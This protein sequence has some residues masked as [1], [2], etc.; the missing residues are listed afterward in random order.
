MKTLDDLRKEINQVDQELTTSFEKRMELVK[1]IIDYKIKH[2]LAVFDESREKQVLENTLAYLKD[3]NLK[4]YQQAFMKETMNLSKSFQTKILNQ[5]N[6]AF[7]GQFGAFSHLAAKDLFPYH[8]LKNYLTFNDIFQALKKD[9]THF[10]VL[11]LENSYY[12]EIGDILDLLMADD[13][14]INASY[15]LKVSHHLMGL[16]G[17]KL[18][19][20]KEVYSHP[21]AISQCS[22]F[23]KG[24][25]V[26]VISYPN[27]ALAAA[28]ILENKDP[29]LA[30]IAS[31]AS[32]E[33]FNLEILAEN[34]HDYA[35]NFTRFVVVSKHHNQSGKYA[36]LLFTTKHQSGALNQILSIISNY[37]FNLESIKSRPYH[38]AAWSYYFYLELDIENQIDKYQDLV[39]ELKLSGGVVKNLGIYNRKDDT[40]PLNLTYY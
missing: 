8:Q 38:Q 21:Q 18:S 14:F 15:D 23:L 6:I 19:E 28:L 25:N 39:R 1:K 16:K 5:N 7:Q 34:I 32:A 22:T 37:G 13:L 26:K 2:N 36:S 4:E 11:P 3:E 33:L 10:G 20:I 35:D 9:E 40:S 31:L 12:G 27:T 24:L 30:A 29:T 17:C